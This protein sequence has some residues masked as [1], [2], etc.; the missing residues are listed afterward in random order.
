MTSS[1]SQKK[2]LIVFIAETLWLGDRI[3]SMQGA[4]D[5]NSDAIAEIVLEWLRTRAGGA[6]SQLIVKVA[7]EQHRVDQISPIADRADE[8][9][10][11]GR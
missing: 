4:A 10:I 5:N 1:G 7:R 2:Y 6:T 3:R 11:L 8:T 9:Y